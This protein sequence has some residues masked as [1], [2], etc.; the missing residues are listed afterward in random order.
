MIFY[1]FLATI[2]LPKQIIA[3]ILLPKLLSDLIFEKYI[4]CRVNFGSLPTGF[5]QRLGTQW[6]YHLS[7]FVCKLYRPPFGMLLIFSRGI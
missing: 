5:K 7:F 1:D 4:L 3:T 6:G 2:L